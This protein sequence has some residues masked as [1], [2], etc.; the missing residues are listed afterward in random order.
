MHNGGYQTL[1]E[2]MEFYNKGGGKGLGL[3]TGNQTLSDTPLN[4]SEK[5]MSEIID[6]LHALNDH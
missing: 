2:V 5:E 4:L 1:R 6:F 3:N